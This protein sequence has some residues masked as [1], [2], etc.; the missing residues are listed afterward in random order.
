MP[1]LPSQS[2]KF[3]IDHDGEL[4]LCVCTSERWTDP[5]W[6]EYLDLVVEYQ[7]KFMV[8]RGVLTFSPTQSPNATQ[9]RIMADE[10]KDKT[11]T[12]RIAR[13]VIMSE[14]TIV[15]GVIT[16]MTWIL[17]KGDRAQ[18]NA[19][20]PADFNQA[21]SWLAEGV[22]FDRARF[23]AVYREAL[24]AVGYDPVTLRPRTG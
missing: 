20:K 22:K 1:L 10:Y 13:L 11:N 6:R 19:F 24:S 23:E 14:S 16:A 15:R 9:R 4:M 2:Q 18:S 7:T 5:M 3:A 8:P 17:P 21:L 12:D